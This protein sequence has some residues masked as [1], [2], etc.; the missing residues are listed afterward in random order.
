MPRFSQ[1]IALAF[2][3]WCEVERAFDA[4]IAATGY[5]RRYHSQ[6]GQD[7]WVIETFGRLHGGFFVELGAGD[8]RTH[9]NTLTLER[10]Y[11]WR[12]LLIEANPHYA[13]LIRMRR[14]AQCVTACI[15]QV[16]GEANFLSLGY[17]SGI[18]GED[19]DHSTAMRPSVVMA[20]SPQRTATRTLASVLEEVAAPNQ[21][22]YLSLDVEGAEYRVLRDFPF[23]R[24]RFSSMTIER[25]SQEL[26]DL[27]SAA[28]YILVRARFFDG[29]YLSDTLAAK[30]KAV[31]IPLIMPRKFF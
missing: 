21:I 19:T 25:P 7:R 26:H 24:Y 2:H 29:F 6:K 30:V 23:D 20:R 13:E 12:G 9:S 15:D 10:D 4:V 28:G 3:Y 17:L 11:R 22:D 14:A 1:A 5:R 31:P 27:L 16:E 8:G 18:I